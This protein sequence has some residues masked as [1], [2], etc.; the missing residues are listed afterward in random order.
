M[1]QL[2]LMELK[3]L[4]AALV[5]LLAAPVSAL[6][7]GYP[8]RPV[9]IVVGF[10]TG[11][12][13]D[14]VARVVAQHLAPLLGQSVVIDNRPGA[15]GVIG[16]DIVA[17]A[18]PN[19]HTLLLVTAGHSTAAAIMRKLPF[20]PV[21]DFAWIST[22]TTYPF[23]IA[24]RPQSQLKSLADVIARGKA[25]P[26]KISYSFARWRRLVDSRGIERQ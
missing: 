10:G 15:G 4:G 9:R 14:I 25:E 23:V 13:A 5:L 7:Q 6:T 17:K 8:D 18:T 2:L 19:G 24:T 12:S 20:E 16:A 22:I 11:G 26:G 1:N 21:N 3:W